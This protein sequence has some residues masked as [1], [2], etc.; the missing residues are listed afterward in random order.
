MFW[1]DRIVEDVKKKYAS[2]TKLIIR[3]EK[4]LSGRVHIGSMRGVA[5][6]GLVAELCQEAGIPHEF[7]FEF[8]DYDPM[9]GLPV[10]LDVE[11][12]KEHMGKPLCNVPS[13]DGI[14]A[15]YAE[16]FG[17]EFA[18]VIAK[19]GF[20][21][22]YYRSSEL[23]K[24][25]KYNKA[26][27]MSLDKAHV[28]RD[29]YK[30][31]SGSVRADDWLALSVICEKCG[32][33]GSTKARNWDGS[34]VEYTCGKFVEWADGCGHQGR[35]DP[36]DGRAK[37][38]WKVEWA[39][40]FM[41]LGVHVEGGGK[42]HST[43][44]G[45][46]EVAEAI[47]REVFEHEP[48]LNIPY[49]F[50]QVGGKKMSSSKGAGSSSQEI[51]D[52]LPAELFRFLLIQKE[53]NKVIEFDPEGE[54]VP[55]LFDNYDSY[56]KKYFEIQKTSESD[57]FARAFQL[58]Q[59]PEHRATI[60]ERHLP[61]FSTVAFI[62][63]MPHVDPVKEIEKLQEITLTEDDKKELAHRIEYVRKWVTTLA[64]A[65]YKFIIQDTTPEAT[66]TFTEVQKQAL[67]AL[68]EYI[69]SVE[70]LDGQ[71]LHTK[72]HEIKETTGI[73]PK[74]FFSA[75]YISVLNRTSGPKAGWFLSVLDRDFLI[76]R[77][78]EVVK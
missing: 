25:G 7:L 17:Q 5:I 70:V 16:Y 9:D 69:K 78:E 12:Y 61:R 41:I 50:F 3:D 11:K 21:P 75:I 51:A 18:Q 56:A 33:V 10:Y 13:P 20:V 67:A 46:R 43:R 54:T 63:Q 47:C 27:R 65:E 8:N 77:F 45:S 49:E 31:I 32:K 58:A 48:P 53:P 1:G 23:Y 35:I 71:G 44:G 38:P 55:I 2:S 28:I 24:T 19:A 15:N 29:I 14:A 6:H 72:M 52:L 59:L 66:K 64:P 37:L 74:A 40:K 22:T 36:F 34:T 68:L 4:T 30:R 76:N 39:A 42:D 26:I 62:S 73:D 57:D 60:T